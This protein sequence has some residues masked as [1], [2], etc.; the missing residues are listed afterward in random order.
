MRTIYK[1]A[2]Y[3]FT[4]LLPSVCP[5]YVPYFFLNTRNF[6]LYSWLWRHKIQERYRTIHSNEARWKYCGR[7]F[8]ANVTE[9]E[10]WRQQWRDWRRVWVTGRSNR[11]TTT[12]PPTIHKHLFLS[13]ALIKTTGIIMAKYRIAGRRKSDGHFSGEMTQRLPQTKLNVFISIHCHSCIAAMTAYPFR[14]SSAPQDIIGRG[15]E[16]RPGSKLCQ[17]LCLPE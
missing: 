9:W 3:I 4:L 13:L 5:S 7:T 11:L 8:D 16:P 10:A 2:L 15:E 17:E 6:L 12:Q 1:P 14:C